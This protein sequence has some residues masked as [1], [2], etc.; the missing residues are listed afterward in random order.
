M[1]NDS[2]EHQRFLKQQAHQEKQ[3][4]FYLEH[5][6]WPANGEISDAANTQTEANTTTTVEQDDSLD[7]LFEPRD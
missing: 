7:Y 3:R 5:G 6:R 1:S 2:N 4:A